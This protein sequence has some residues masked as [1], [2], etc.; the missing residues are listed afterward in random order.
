MRARAQ[1]SADSYLA[2]PFVL[3]DSQLPGQRPELLRQLGGGKPACC[4][5][6]RACSSGGRMA[7]RRLEG[8]AL[9]A[10]LALLLLPPPPLAEAA[11]GQRVACYAADWAIVSAKWGVLLCSG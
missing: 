9:L 10:V 2:S 11:L 5:G 1:R 7:R 6:R 3:Q 4:I 8:A